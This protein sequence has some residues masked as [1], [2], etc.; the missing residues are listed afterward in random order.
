M[1]FAVP[2]GTF[3]KTAPSGS[4]LSL[5]RHSNG[6]DRFYSALSESEGLS[7]LDLSGASQAN[8]TF[9]T[10]AGHRMSSDDIVGAMLQSFGDNFAENQQTEGRAIRF[11][12]QALTFPAESFDGALVWDAFQFLAP[13]LIDRTVERLLRVMRPGG[14]ILAFFNANEKIKE[15]PLYNYRIQDAKTLLQIPRGV[16]QRVQNFNNRSIERLFE[17]A[18]SVKVFLTRDNLREV[19]VRR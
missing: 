10:E 15:I 7:V 11:L 1:K 5:T 16:P 13:P 9:I 18:E 2:K 14:L 19:L 8:I 4:G 17:S 12:E 6:F 3:L